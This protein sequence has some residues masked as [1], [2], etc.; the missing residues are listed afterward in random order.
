MLR[1]D[2]YVQSA[3]CHSVVVWRSDSVMNRLDDLARHT[4]TS[5]EG[6]A[7]PA[8]SSFVAEASLPAAV[9]AGEP[10][11]PALWEFPAEGPHSAGTAA[12]VARTSTRHWAMYAATAA[13]IFG[14]I[15]AGTWGARALQRSRPAATQ[16]AAAPV[17]NAPVVGTPVDDPA[18]LPAAL[19]PSVE[20]RPFVGA[21]VARVVANPPRIAD[22]ASR[23]V[24]DD[25]QTRDTAATTPR[26]TSGGASTA[27]R[28]T[29]TTRPRTEPVPPPAA[30]MA[31]INPAVTSTPPQASPV[32]ETPAAAAPPAQRI[33]AAI[34]RPEPEA[35]PSV[36]ARSDQS[37]IQRTLGQYRSAY[38][39]LD[40]EGA[41]AVWPSVDVRALARAFDTLSSQEL[42]FETCLFDIAGPVATAQCRGSATY[43][44][45]VG[46]R[47]PKAERRQWTFRLRKVNEA[48]KIESAQAKR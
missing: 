11:K 47:G 5:S 24:P 7:A 37:E 34:A 22:A 28:L 48:W 12:A 36:V 14:G 45:K 25:R 46:G 30:P 40:A 2:Q 27:A 15:L 26:G 21:P 42:E 19:I 35:L 1:S 23:P 9:S 17:V 8:L 38:G 39:R 18:K 33:P 3:D 41:Q 20:L 29:P 13:V 32:V 43:T 44:P 31:A 16:A 4:R 10:A 6:A